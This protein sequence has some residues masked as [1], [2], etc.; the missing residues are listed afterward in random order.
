MS[1]I[2][3]YMMSADGIADAEYQLYLAERRYA[4]VCAACALAAPRVDSATLDDI[5]YCAEHE[6]GSA[7]ERL[8]VS[9]GY[10]CA[11]HMYDAF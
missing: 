4:A 3:A 9:R 7:H 10:T 8:A 1:A 2:K 11:H 5:L 6:L